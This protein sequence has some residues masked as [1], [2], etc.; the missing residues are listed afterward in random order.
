MAGRGGGGKVWLS[1]LV[2]VAA[3]AALISHLV[4]RWASLGHAPLSIWWLLLLAAAVPV[5]IL[6][7]ARPFDEPLPCAL[8]A[9]LGAGIGVGM[10][11]ALASPAYWFSP[12]VAWHTAKVAAVAS[13]AVLQDPIYQVPTMYPFA[14]HLLPAVAHSFG[15]PL[16][17]VMTCAP[18]LALAAT[19]AAFW[20]LARTCIEDRPAAWA[21]LALPLVFHA[22]LFGYILLPEPFNGSLALVFLALALL[23][24]GDRERCPRRLALGGLVLGL[25]GLCWYGHLVWIAGFVALLAVVRRHVL[26]AMVVGGLAPSGLLLWHLAALPEG[27]L[28][29]GGGVLAAGGAESVAVRIPGMLANLLSLSG[30]ADLAAAPWWIGAMVLALLASTA[31]RW[32][33]LPDSH[34]LL[35]AL[36][37]ALLLCLAWAGLRLRYWEPFSWRYAML[38]WSVVL[39][40]AAW[41]ADL[42][43]S[44]WRLPAAAPL[45]LVALPWLAWSLLP[46][47]GSSARLAEQYE[48][49]GRDLS[50]FVELH[51]DPGDPV[52]AS[53]ATWEHALGCCTPRPNLADRD[54]GT[55]KYA[56]AAIAQPRFADYQALSEASGTDAV[57]SILA[58]YGFQYAVLHR[59]DLRKPGYLALARGF[60]IVFNNPDYLV[61]ELDGAAG[62]RRK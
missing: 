37:V 53:I 52:F 47:V 50:A 5:T 44:S 10:A 33:V 13:G 41:R 38:L 2:G 4:A 59:M 54:G 57:R 45:A 30:G 14:W 49:T 39:L 8:A 28:S 3:S 34:Q 12:D 6:L 26:P 56:P 58:P 22:P 15:V 21:A 35:A 23:L 11:A 62:S 46:V 51:T 55:Y 27:A 29:A 60:T 48:A 17:E 7:C 1:W 25:A 36:V 40:L 43:I 9:G 18:A 42:E 61:V 16:R 31:R 19:S 24:R 32:T 20:L